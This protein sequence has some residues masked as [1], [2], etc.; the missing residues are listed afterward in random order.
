[1]PFAVVN[2]LIEEYNTNGISSVLRADNI[3]DI[4]LSSVPE[5][6]FGIS[7]YQSNS[8]L[9]NNIYP[10]RR[11]GGT[12][13]AFQRNDK[14]WSVVTGTSQKDLSA[15]E[16]AS[17]LKSE[18][19]NAGIPET[20]NK[21]TT[22][23]AMEIGEF[24]T[25]YTTASKT[26]RGG[27][28]GWYDSFATLSEQVHGY[29]RSRWF[30]FAAKAAE[31]GTKEFFK[32]VAR[33]SLSTT[34]GNVAATH[35][36]RDIVKDEDL[37]SKNLDENG[38][39][40]FDNT[41]NDPDV[42]SGDESMIG[43]TREQSVA[44]VTAKFISVASGIES[45]VC[46]G[47]E[48]LMGVQT[49]ISTYQRIQKINL[50]A[51]YM[52]AVQSVQAGST[53]SDPMHEYNNRLTTNDPDTGKNAMSA[54]GMGA[55]FS[56][57]VISADDAS[58]QAVNTEK[59]LSNVSNSTD[60]DILKVFGDVAGNVSAMLTAYQTCNYLKGALH[61]ASAVVTVLSIIPAIGQGIA[62][63]NLTA[64]TIIAATVKALIV[65]AA[66]IIARE[67]VKYAGNLLIKDMATDWVGEDLGNALVSGGNSLLSA[68]HQTGGGSP[69]SRA[70][71]LAFRREQE[72]IIAEEA[73]YQ[74]SIR[75]P[76][77]INSQY[78]FLGSIVYSLVPMANS[79]GVGSTLKSINSIMTN[80]V[81]KILP[82][83]SAM[84]E[85]NLVD[86]L[87]EPGD[88]P[89]LEIV[90]I[91]GDIYCNPIY[92]TDESTIDEKNSPESIIAKEA[93][94]IEKNGGKITIRDNT[95]LTNYINYCGQRAS[96]FG[97]PDANIANMIRKRAS[98]V[99]ARVA[100]NFPVSGDIMAAADAANEQIN[101]PWTTGAA[102]VASDDNPKWATN[103][104][105]QRFMEDQRQIENYDTSYDN[106]VAVYLN[107]YYT[108]NPIDDSFE[109][110]LARFS[111]MTKEDVIATLEL[112]DGLNYIANYHP[113]ER[114]AFGI[115]ETDDTI[116]FEET[117]D[118]FA[119]FVAAEP[120]Y[121]I[122]DTLRNKATIG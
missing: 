93:N 38:N 77:D 25:P 28:A 113:E 56:E 44:R 106:A 43:K 15:S 72:R 21:V 7:T 13:L 42:E 99:L 92:I 18:Y 47:I 30:K 10:L 119:R 74:R 16:I 48:G 22:K 91:Q 98:S 50:V 103:K 116:Y 39:E 110:T 60:S 17:A 33:S 54:A 23:E 117:E 29:T 104:I 35:G 63:F 11:G 67:V 32:T 2:R 58:V 97:L 1:M 88:C 109:G 71:V 105:H 89:S 78:T 100:S 122:Y 118:D 86:D 66:P 108:K 24:K 80:A 26:W 46:A 20:I 79:S 3:L 85:T 52:E 121:I 19:P 40:A 14:S 61:I 31:R 76:F 51:G 45:V 81:S 41:T 6:M 59:V 69:A 55:L 68:N 34:S 107:D 95:E 9:E 37:G 111:G 53:E 62:A 102:C 12:L 120:K 115:E 87:A 75:S 112:I 114:L 84:A 90:G 8:L 65:A 49:L 5:T 27:N 83:A 94:N 73:E 57:E 64:K 70:K 96:S 36:E 4:Q 82:T 101:M